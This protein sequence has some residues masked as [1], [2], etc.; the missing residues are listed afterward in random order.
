MP[1]INSKNEKNSK[2]LSIQTNLH[3]LMEKIKV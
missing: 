3:K 1:E 2:S